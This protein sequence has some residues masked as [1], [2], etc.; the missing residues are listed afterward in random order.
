MVAVIVAA[1]SGRATAIVSVHCTAAPVGE[2]VC[3][4]EF[5][6]RR[7]EPVFGLSYGGNLFLM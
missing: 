7:Q 2:L 3:G 6:I 4:V 1:L 5:F